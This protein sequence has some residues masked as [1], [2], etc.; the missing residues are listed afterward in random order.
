MIIFAVSTVCVIIIHRSLVASRRRHTIEIENSVRANLSSASN[1]NSNVGKAKA[2]WPRLLSIVRRARLFVQFALVGFAAFIYPSFINSVYFL[3]FLIIAFI[4][5]ASVKFGRK[6]AIA[7]A[8]LVIYTGVHLFIFYLYQFEFFQ[9]ELSPLSLWSNLT[10]LTAIVTNNCSQREPI[11]NGN[12]SWSEYLNPCALLLLY[13]YF[14]FETNRTFFF[15]VKIEK[16]SKRFERSFLDFFC[17]IKRI[18]MRYNRLNVRYRTMILNEFVL[19]RLCPWTHHLF[20]HREI[21]IGVLTD[22]FDHWAFGILSLLSA[23]FFDHFTNDYQVCSLSFVVLEFS[24]NSRSTRDIR[25]KFNRFSTSRQ[26]RTKRR[27]NVAR[28]TYL[29]YSF[30]TSRLRTTKL[31]IS[32]D[33][34][35]GERFFFVIIDHWWKI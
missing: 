31:F 2:V 29:R 21:H 18:P 9:N 10:G 3:F 28:K 20:F 13:F 30:D 5:S 11:F 1:S 22:R 4:W 33:C 8:A 26:C 24:P 23:F 7:R 14:A 15:K 19:S 27:S 32:I 17:R 34:D 6:F 25:W 35:A 16:K 12:L